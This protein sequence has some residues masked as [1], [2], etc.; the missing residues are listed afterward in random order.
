[1]YDLKS[2][3]AN[4]LIFPLESLIKLEKTV[5]VDSW[6]IPYKKDE[7]L[8]RLLKSTLVFA[9]KSSAIFSTKS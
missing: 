7:L 9:R 3:N 8:D 6:S 5:S 2:L 1:M 4:R